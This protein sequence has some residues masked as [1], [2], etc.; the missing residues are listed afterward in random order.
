MLLNAYVFTVQGNGTRSGQQIN[1]YW[2]QPRQS[3]LGFARLSWHAHQINLL[4]KTQHTELIL[5][6]VTTDNLNIEGWEQNQCNSGEMSKCGTKILAA[7][8]HY[9]DKTKFVMQIK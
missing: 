9:L 5:G 1:G 6:V 3:P 8:E 2:E 4:L 7:K